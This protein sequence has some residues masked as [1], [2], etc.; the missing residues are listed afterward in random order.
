MTDHQSYL[1]SS[2]LWKAE[3]IAKFLHQS[4]WA[5]HSDFSKRC[6]SKQ[7][8]RMRNLSSSLSIFLFFSSLHFPSCWTWALT[9]TEER[10]KQGA[11]LSTIARL[12]FILIKMASVKA[13]VPVVH[14]HAWIHAPVWTLSICF[15]KSSVILVCS[16][17]FPL[18]PGSSG[19]LTK[20]C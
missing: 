18:T 5:V 4:A 20:R 14:T 10:R 13:H 19:G 3:D 7:H 1:L 2:T 11:R 12:L 9:P 16:G 17:I 15:T 6:T 8:E